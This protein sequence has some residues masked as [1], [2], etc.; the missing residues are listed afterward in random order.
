M[1]LIPET[2]DGLDP[3]ANSYVTLAEAVAYWSNVAGFDYTTLQTPVIE[4]SLIQATHYIE[5]NYR[6]LFKGV[7][8]E[9]DQPLG[10]PR[11]GIYWECSELPAMPLQLKYATFEYAKRIL[12]SDGEGIQPDPADRDA[13][14]NQLKYTFRKVGPLENKVEYLP[15]SGGITIQ[16]YPAADGWLEP[17]TRSYSGRTV[18]A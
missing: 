9:E 4:R 16:S 1:A 13:T 2:G 7:K 8:L 15:G 10:F 12:E 3:T 17:L 18:R 6:S 14:G 11:E 5:L